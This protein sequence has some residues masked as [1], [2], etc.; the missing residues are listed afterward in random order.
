MYY[1]FSLSGDWHQCRP[2]INKTEKFFN[3]IVVQYVLQNYK[4]PSVPQTL[5]R[6]TRDP[7]LTV[8]PMVWQLCYCYGNG[9]ILVRMK[10]FSKI[11]KKTSIVHSMK[12]F[13]LF[14]KMKQKKNQNGRLKKGQFSIFFCENSWIGPWVSRIDW[15][16]MH[17]CVSTNMDVRLSDISSKTGKKCRTAS[18]PYRLSHV[19]AL[20]INQSY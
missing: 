14:N 4:N 13:G 7:R 20:R 9:S 15:C 12:A 17:W 18:Q 10:F 3:P 2:E 1:K 6:P 5:E 8:P 19:N 16:E 11:L